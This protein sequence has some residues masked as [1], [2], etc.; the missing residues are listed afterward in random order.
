MCSTSL[1]TCSGPPPYWGYRPVALRLYW[2]YTPI[3]CPQVLILVG[4]P[5]GANDKRSHRR[6]DTGSP[7]LQ[8]GAQESV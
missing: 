4:D 6:M 5:T 7:S 1:G 3:P 2:G 8:R